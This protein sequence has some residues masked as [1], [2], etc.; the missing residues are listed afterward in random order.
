LDLVVKGEIVR[1]QVLS[2]L[3]NTSMRWI[4]DTGTAKVRWSFV[5]PQ[6]MS[7]WWPRA[8]ISM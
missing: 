4:P 3:C 6:E 5:G 1:P 7:D 2:L 8:S